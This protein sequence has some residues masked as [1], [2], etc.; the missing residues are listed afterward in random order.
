MWTV[1]AGAVLFNLFSVCINAISALRYRRLIK[2]LNEA[3]EDYKKLPTSCDVV[4]FEFDM[5][6]K[7]STFPQ[8]HFNK[9]PVN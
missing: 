2:Q 7:G 8:E 5:D 1:L 4:D 3:Q 9:Y 6:E